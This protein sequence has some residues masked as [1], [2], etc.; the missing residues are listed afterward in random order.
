MRFHWSELCIPAG[1]LS[2]VRR[3][4]AALYP[5]PSSRTSRHLGLIVEEV[6]DNTV[7]KAVDLELTS[8]HPSIQV[9]SRKFISECHDRGLVVYVF[10][11]NEKRDFDKLLSMGVDGIFTDYP[12]KFISEKI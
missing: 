7:E 9:A 2:T 4:D 8:I 12:D 11:V 3:T 10:T 5:A 1:C 6:D